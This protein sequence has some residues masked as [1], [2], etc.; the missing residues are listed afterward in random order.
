[1]LRQ[2]AEKHRFSAVPASHAASGSAEAQSF[3]A[4]LV[5]GGLA[6][7][8]AEWAFRCRELGS[9]GQSL[10]GGVSFL[11]EPCFGRP[12]GEGLQYLA[13]CWSGDVLQYFHSPEDTQI[14]RGQ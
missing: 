11:R 14:R 1:M 13:S 8:A 7:S 4:N 3:L 5:L 10:Q 12:R 2:G 6:S 9:L